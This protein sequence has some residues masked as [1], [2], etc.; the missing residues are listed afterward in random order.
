M[1]LVLKLNM[2]P[3]IIFKTVQIVPRFKFNMFLSTRV[4]LTTTFALSVVGDP[5]KT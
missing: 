4:F 2:T 5:E 1:S 3:R